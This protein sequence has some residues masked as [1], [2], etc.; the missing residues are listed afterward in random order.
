[1]SNINN[2]F[3][4]CSIIA[5]DFN[6]RCSRWW[7]NDITNSTG[8]EIDS[9]TSSVDINKLLINLPMLLII[10][11]SCIDLIFCTNKNVISNYGLDVSVFKSCQHNIIHGKIG[12]RAPLQPVYICEVWDYDKANV[13]NIKKA[14]SNFNWNRAF[15]NLFYR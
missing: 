11:M 4:L 2:E 6:A 7:K 13:E 5:G 1:M 8:Q 12:I 15:E 10:S 9:L 14:V 3:P